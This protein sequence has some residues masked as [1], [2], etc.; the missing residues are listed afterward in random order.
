MLKHYYSW[1]YT[2]NVLNSDVR[3]SLVSCTFQN[4]VVTLERRATM[5]LYLPREVPQSTN[6]TNDRIK[7]RRCS[8]MERLNSYLSFV[9]CWFEYLFTKYVIMRLIKHV[10]QVCNLTKLLTP[11]KGQQAENW[12]LIMLIKAN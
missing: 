1:Y 4:A 10:I 8:G 6:K 3:E 12:Y 9:Y 2:M 5:Y 11:R 7:N